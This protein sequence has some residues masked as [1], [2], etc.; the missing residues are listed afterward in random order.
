M[1]GVVDLLQGGRACLEYILDVSS[2]RRQVRVPKCEAL[3]RTKDV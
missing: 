1:E 3:G 2:S